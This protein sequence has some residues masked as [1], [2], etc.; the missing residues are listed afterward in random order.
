MFGNLFSTNKELEQGWS[1]RTNKRYREGESR[2]W[3]AFGSGEKMTRDRLVVARGPGLGA[4]G[5][6]A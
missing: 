3:V 4:W 6:R 5:R 1:N 2:G